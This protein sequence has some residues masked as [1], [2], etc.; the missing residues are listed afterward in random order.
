LKKNASL[1]IQERVSQLLSLC[2]QQ[3]VRGLIVVNFL[4]NC[5]SGIQHT[6]LPLILSNNLQLS[7]VEVGYMVSYTGVVACFG[8]YPSSM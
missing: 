1:S 5:A 8:V 4:L 2:T 7:V 6:A 3:R